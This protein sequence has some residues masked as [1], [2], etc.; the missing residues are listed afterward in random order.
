[1]LNPDAFQAR[2]PAR[3]DLKGK[4]W[5]VEELGSKS[6]FANP[7]ETASVPFGHV[8]VTVGAPLVIVVESDAVFSFAEAIPAAQ[9]NTT[10]VTAPS[11]SHLHFEPPDR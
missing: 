11:V 5:G 2:F 7:P 9:S 3:R 1:V 8:A 4:I 10:A 6:G